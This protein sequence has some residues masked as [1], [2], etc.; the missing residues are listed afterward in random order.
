MPHLMVDYS[1]NLEDSVDIAGLCNVLRLAAIET[2]A[3]PLPGVRVRA[4]RADHV[5]IADGDPTHGYIDISIR[6]RAGR[7]L[8]TRKAATNDIF[9]AAKAFLEPAMAQHSIALSMEMRDID[10]ELSP[11]YGTIRD[12]LK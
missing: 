7:D 12:H 3:L 8:A 6:L 1:P 11:K 5:S 4:T 2:G 10:P 9:A